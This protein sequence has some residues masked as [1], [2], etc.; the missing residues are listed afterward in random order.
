MAFPLF[1]SLCLVDEYPSSLRPRGVAFVVLVELGR[2]RADLPVDL[3][4]V[5]LGLGTLEFA[6]KPLVLGIPTD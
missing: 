3:V 1:G 2:Q 4:D 5:L 6:H